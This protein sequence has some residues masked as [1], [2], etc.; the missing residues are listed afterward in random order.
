MTDWP[1]FAKDYLSDDP[2]A[3]KSHLPEAYVCEQIAHPGR[4]C[5]CN[6]DQGNL[7]TPCPYKE[8]PNE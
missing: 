3:L 4:T 8:T 1:Q 5:R 6:D 2:E 7:R